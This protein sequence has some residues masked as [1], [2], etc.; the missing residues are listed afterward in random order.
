LSIFLPASFTVKWYRNKK[1]S[2]EKKEKYRE[3]CFEQD[4]LI[5]DLIVHLELTIEEVFQMK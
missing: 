5:E 1:Y 4:T 2:G 3:E